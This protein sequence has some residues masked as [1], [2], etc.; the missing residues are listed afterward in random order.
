MKPAVFPVAPET[1]RRAFGI[2]FPEPGVPVLQ[3]A[4]RGTTRTR[5]GAGSLA[6]V[7][8]EITFVCRRCGGRHHGLP[9]SYGTQAPAYWDPSLAGDE[10]SM[11]E[12][13]Q[14]VI[15]AE[16][17]FVRGRLVIPVTGADPGTEFD[18][19]AWVSLSRDNFTRALSLWTTAGHE[20]E[21]P[22]FG[23]LSNELPMYQPSTLSMKTLVH[24]KAAGQRPLIELEPT[25]HP[26]AVEQRTGITLAR[27]QGI[28]E[29][30]LHLLCS[31]CL[32]GACA[33]GWGIVAGKPVSCSAGRDGAAEREPA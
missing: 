11:L 21:Q 6:R 15:K 7:A 31:R 28:A 29:T 8:S 5:S 9:M 30:L 24:T 33:R 13:E 22:Y 19:G 12:Q 23:W 4:H 16:H 2:R 1:G 26:L 18:W 3:D 17:F 25:D 14:C 10:S 27:V 32:C 20:R